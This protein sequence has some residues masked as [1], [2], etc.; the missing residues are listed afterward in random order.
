MKYIFAFFSKM[1]HKYCLRDSFWRSKFLETYF[2][3]HYNNFFFKYKK[4]QQLW[5]RPIGGWHPTS[6]AAWFD[7]LDTLIGRNN[8]VFSNIVK[9]PLA[10]A[11]YHYT[12]YRVLLFILYVC[13]RLKFAGDVFLMFVVDVLGSFQLPCGYF[14]IPVVDPILCRVVSLE[15]KR[16]II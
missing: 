1:Y 6:Q 11:H 16:H 15:K 12:A 3:K 10:H 13:E 4:R 7:T 9:L 8:R 2:R 14:Y 5:V